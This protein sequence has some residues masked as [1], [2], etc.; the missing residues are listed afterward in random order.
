M[1][2]ERHSDKSHV[3]M[4]GTGLRIRKA[5][6][7]S[8]SAPNDPGQFRLVP[9]Q[10]LYIDTRYQR[11]QV[12]QGKVLEIAKN[13]DWR[14]FGALA[15]VER[16]DG[17]L[18]IYDGGHRWRASQHRDEIK[19]LPCMVFKAETLD[20]EAKAFIGTNT[21]KSNVSAFH[22]FKASVQAGEP[23]ATA[24]QA[25]L[26][27]YGFKASRDHSSKRGIAAI[28]TLRKMVS[29][30]PE[31]A[32]SVFQLC[33]E[34]GTDQDQLTAQVMRSIFY[35]ASHLDQ[36]ILAGAWRKKL[37]TIGIAGIEAG[38]RRERQILGKGG[39]RVEAKA[40]LDL[41]NK[42]KRTRLKL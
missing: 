3:T 32:D 21:M 22:V 8:W 36:N 2:I 37:I 42:G 34:M 6:K 12:S 11:E 26:D 40:L 13:W 39:E 30:D 5:E 9:K 23:N 33:V 19:K 38:I 35:L 20:E 1:F 25:L 16:P 41:L 14:I 31:L 27:K 18:W 7:F 24:T 10:E 15:V 4:P 17:S 28:G 29:T